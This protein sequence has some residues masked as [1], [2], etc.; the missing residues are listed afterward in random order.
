MRHIG[1][2]P[3]WITI[4]NKVKYPVDIVQRYETL[5]A[6][7]VKIFE[8]EFAKRL[9][10]R[11]FIV[12][13]MVIQ[14]KGLTNENMMCFANSSFQLLFASPFFVSF[15][16]FMKTNLPLF[17]PRQL[18]MIPTWR[19]FC[20]FL[21]KFHFSDSS[22][23]DGALP[24]LKSLQ[25]TKIEFPTNLQILNPVFGPYS[26]KRK[27][28][29]QEDA[30]EFLSFFINK[31][32]DELL[33]LMRLTSIDE[34]PEEKGQWK[35]QGSN[36]KTVTLQETQGEM[37]PLSDVFSTIIQSDTMEN[38]VTRSANKES[39]VVLPLSIKGCQTLDDCLAQFTSVERID[40]KVSKRTI[41]LLT[42]KTLIISLKRFSFD[43]ITITPIKLTNI[44]DYPDILTMN[45]LVDQ[46]PIQY[47]LC[48]IVKHI[49]KSPNGGHYVCYA[50][51][52]DGRWVYFDDSNVSVIDDNH[53]LGL[54]A[55]LLLY[56]QITSVIAETE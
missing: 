56:N 23:S 33:E 35:V 34:S 22:T 14:P 24:S 5:M 32:H 11:E 47:R 4:S 51:R 3:H 6:D 45:R 16:Y 30:A 53:H 19:L 2:E 10:K 37:S 26:S 41:F 50:R 13:N 49:G 52:F 21:S 8:P 44:I 42:P 20:Q 46:K 12:R 17:S 27:P 29:L 15:S 31:L 25:M 7:S 43:P 54:E 40:S 39:L 36:R 1:S 55:Y 48:G 18:S 28:V 9:A 38:T